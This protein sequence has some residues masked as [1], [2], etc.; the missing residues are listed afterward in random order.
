MALTQINSNSIADGSITNADISSSAA[1][2]AARVSDENES[3]VTCLCDRH[4]ESSKCQAV[5]PSGSVP[6]LRKFAPRMP[7]PFS[8]SFEKPE[9]EKASM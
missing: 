4:G 8:C 9:S 3:R 7:Y 2:T 6:F 1:I 5:D